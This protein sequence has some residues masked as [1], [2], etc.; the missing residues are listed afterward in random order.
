MRQK[1]LELAFGRTLRRTRTLLRRF[2]DRWNR[3]RNRCNSRVLRLSRV[4]RTRPVMS[5]MVWSV[6]MSRMMSGMA[7]RMFPMLF[8]WLFLLQLL[9]RRLTRLRRKTAECHQ[10]WRRFAV[11][12]CRVCFEY[13]RRWLWYVDRRWTRLSRIDGRH[14]QHKT[15]RFLFRS[16]GLR[17]IPLVFVFMLL[18][19]SGTTHSFGLHF[20]INFEECLN[21]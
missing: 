17:V 4:M 1:L 19:L 12:D 13:R 9:R 16:I 5:S 20:L 6:P 11:I 7:V 3:S 10:F 21:R 14:F 18:M 2:S 15:K 8:L